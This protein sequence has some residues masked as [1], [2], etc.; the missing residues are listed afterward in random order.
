VHN[1]ANPSSDHL[2]GFHHHLSLAAGAYQNAAWVV[3]VAKAGK[4]RKASSRSVALALW[5]RRGRL[6]RRRLPW[7]TNWSW[8]V[9]ISI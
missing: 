2:A 8:L 4:S 3:A 1:P 6:W 5:P 9:A 7:R